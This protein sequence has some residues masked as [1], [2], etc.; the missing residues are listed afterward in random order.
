MTCSYA[1]SRFILHFHPPTHT[2]PDIT[3]PNAHTYTIIARIMTRMPLFS[4]GRQ[5]VAVF[6]GAGRGAETQQKHQSRAGWLWK[7]VGRRYHVHLIQFSEF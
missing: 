2:S 1:A 5:P 6:L 3:P 7:G 4:E